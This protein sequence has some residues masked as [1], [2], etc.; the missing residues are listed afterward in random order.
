MIQFKSKLFEEIQVEGS[1]T[2]TATRRF[3]F[4]RN[5]DLRILEAG[6]LLV[7]ISTSTN[8]LK[9]RYTITEN[10][11][12]HQIDIENNSAI[13][14]DNIRYELKTDRLYPFKTKYADVQIDREKVGEMRFAKKGFI[15]LHLEFVPEPNNHLTPDALLKTSILVLLNIADLDGSE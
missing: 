7:A 12:G 1:I 6:K 9:T 15:N 5:F 14:F 10:A 8:F 11:T 2:L 3:K 4:M 13:N